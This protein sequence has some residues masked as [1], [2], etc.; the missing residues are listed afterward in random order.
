[1]EPG[2]FVHACAISDARHVNQ[3]LFDGLGAVEDIATA[4]V[5]AHLAV[6]GAGDLKTHTLPYVDF[7]YRFGGRLLQGSVY[8]DPTLDEASIRAA[9]DVVAAPRSLIQT[10]GPEL[11]AVLAPQLPKWLSLWDATARLSLFERD[12]VGVFR[13]TFTRTPKGYRQLRLSIYDSTR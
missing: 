13:D 3:L 10:G 4:M 12:A 6:I 9:S 1:M 5:N 11:E 8:W 7:E 2:K